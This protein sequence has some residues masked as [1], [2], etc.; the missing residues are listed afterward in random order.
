MLQTS[1]TH[2]TLQSRKHI[3]DAPRVCQCHMSWLVMQ[4]DK[5]DDVISV[6]FIASE[7]DKA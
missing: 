2:D 1:R 5:E 4:L 3:S 6:H 7:I